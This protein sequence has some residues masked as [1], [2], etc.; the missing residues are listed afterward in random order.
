M[1][2]AITVGTTLLIL[3]LAL[4]CENSDNSSN[5][6]PD[7][8]ADGDSDGDSDSDSDGDSDSD[9]DGDSDSDSD[10]DSDSDS[11]GDS[12][13]DTDTETDTTDECATMSDHAEIK[14]LP[15]DII[16]AVDNSNSMTAE[17]LWV[18]NNLNGFSSQIAASGVDY[19]IVLISENNTSDE[20][21]CVAAPLGNGN[22]PDDSNPPNY[23]HIPAGVSSTNALAV[24][25][26][27]YDIWKTMLRPDSIKHFLVVSDD[28]ADNDAATFTTWM[29]NRGITDFT[30]HAIVASAGI[31]I[32]LNCLNGGSALC[33]SNTKPS[34][35]LGANRGTVYIE[36]ATQTGGIW[37]NLCKQDFG[38][39][40]DELATLVSE[41]SFACEWDIPDPPDGEVFDPN[42][43]NIKFSDG[44]GG[45]HDVGYVSDPSQCSN[46]QHGWY[47][48][49]PADPTTILVCDQTCDW[50]KNFEDGSIEIIFGCETKP[51]VVV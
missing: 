41:V 27:T 50:I 49:N 33:C 43:V 10:G 32:A 16:I 25:N 29:A 24:I 39:V 22:C 13:S 3:I 48:D 40:F 19:H 38:P 30:F 20:G 45:E 31:E 26:D 6:A 21:I 46:V 17:A 15:V 23:L 44:T 34:L 37:G 4:G 47:Y 2:R 11:D 35:P 42:K 5:G 7:G 14:S 1:Q 9:S 8:G 12:D 36:L 18:Q 28:N 51:A